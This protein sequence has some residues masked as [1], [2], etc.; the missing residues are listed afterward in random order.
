MPRLGELLRAHPGSS[1]TARVPIDVPHTVRELAKMCDPPLTTRSMRRRLLRWHR[2]HDEAIMVKIEGQWQCTIA[3]LRTVWPS[4]GQKFAEQEDI[5]DLGSRIEK[6]TGRIRSCEIGLK[7][8][9]AQANS[10]Y[11]RVERIEKVLVAAGQ[12]RPEETTRSG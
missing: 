8:F 1:V 2:A 10:W 4:F 5:D 9:R 3:S 6:N 11:R 12:L 7:N